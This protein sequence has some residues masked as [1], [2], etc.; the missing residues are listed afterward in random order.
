MS[1]Y[2]TASQFR[3]TQSIGKTTCFAALDAAFGVVFPSRLNG[4]SRSCSLTAPRKKRG[5]PLQ[6]TA[7]YLKVFLAPKKQ[8]WLDAMV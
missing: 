6:P 2:S 8:G 3:L 4:A 7:S 5:Q 1:I